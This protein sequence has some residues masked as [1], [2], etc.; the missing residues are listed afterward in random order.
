[1]DEDVDRSLVDY[2]LGQSD[3]ARDAYRASLP[4]LVANMTPEQRA[5]DVAILDA[6][7]FERLVENETLRI[8]QPDLGPL[9][10]Q[11]YSADPPE[12]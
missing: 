3:Q 7:R 5:N 1:M 12:A 2:W 4:E 8:E 6:R 11:A 10:D 9:L